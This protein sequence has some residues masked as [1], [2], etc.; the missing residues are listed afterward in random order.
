VV[1]VDETSMVSLTLMSRLLEAV[2]PE[3]RLVL[4]GDPDQLASVEAG[5]VLGDLVA[6]PP[7]PAAAAPAEAAAKQLFTV[8]GTDLDAGEAPADVLACGVVRLTR[9]HRFGG[10]IGELAEAVRGGEADRVVDL[11]R[12]GAPGVTFVESVDLDSRAPA[13]I[14]EL[15]ADVV[16]TGRAVVAAARAGDAAAALSALD[17]HRLL[18]AHRQGP[19]GVARWSE[20]VERW[21]SAAI[22][23]FAVDGEWYRGRPLL[24][25]TNDYE[26]KLF[27]GDTGVVVDAGDRGTLAVF[28]RGNAEPLSLAP[29]RLSGVQ[30]VHAMTVHRSQGSQFTRVSLILP[31]EESPLLT[32]ELFYTAVTRA[33]EGVRVL[34]TE[35]AVRAAVSRPILR[36]SGLRRR[37]D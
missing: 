3:A 5:A 26:L 17:G 21:L 15:R 24:A 10:T 9:T 1:V 2:R 37:F 4:V 14:A 31:P 16:E 19:F 30:T 22:E 33:S 28:G 12:N 35:A 8:A 32:R 27:N 29:S 11:L 6:R 18:C 20:E 23:G 34:G 13:G 7:A 36:A 25:T